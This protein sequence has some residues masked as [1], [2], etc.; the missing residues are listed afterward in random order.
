[1]NSLLLLALA[2]LLVATTILAGSV[3]RLRRQRRRLALA[4]GADGA[5]PSDAVI[6]NMVRQATAAGEVPELRSRLDELLRNSPT[7]LLLLDDDC[8]ISELS[9]SASEEFEQP[10][11]GRGLL[12]TLGSHELEAATRQALV[13]MKPAR[14]NVRL[15]ATGRRPFRARLFPYQAGSRRECLLF[16]QD[17]S[18]LVDYGELR[19]QFAAT[20]SHEL[21]TPLAGIRATVETLLDPDISDDDRAR[22]LERVS[23]ET[24][25][26][27]QLIEEIL[28]LS[29]LESGAAT[30][31]EGSTEL[32]ELAGQLMEKLA[33]PASEFEVSMTAD[34]PD[35]IRLPLPERMA[36]TVLAN[37]LE[38]A[39]KYS[40]RGSRIDI[41]AGQ[42]EGR[43]WLTVRDNG[44]GVE[45][46][47]LPHIFER[48]YRV[49]KSRS[50]RLGG[51]G[52]GLSIV[53]HVAEHAGGEVRIQSREGFGTEVTVLLTIGDV[54]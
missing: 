27:E 7:P 30:Q 14:L 46:E 19:S 10:P 5:I 18:A 11:R 47:H 23:R 42:D 53:K 45:A 29:S 9:L 28:F 35:G 2:G 26:L 50:R 13:E 25:H 17:A 49:D 16:L 33:A 41:T 8:V 15:Y 22:F 38:N 21:R 36:A 54:A 20:V 6:V 48:F 40:G 39:I 32:R 44:V 34:I 52:L 31:V 43:V 1:M 37:L 12:E 51:T 3:V 24:S 4:L